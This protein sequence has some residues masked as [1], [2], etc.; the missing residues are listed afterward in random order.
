MIFTSECVWKREVV[1]KVVKGKQNSTMASHHATDENS[2]PG[3]SHSA[4]FNW[5]RAKQETNSIKY[6]QEWRV[7]MTQ[8][9][10]N[11]FQCVQPMDLAHFSTDLL[12]FL[13]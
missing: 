3:H 12:Y 13:P 9:T 5:Q 7:Q 4:S 8:L 11:Q 6:W 2:S 1:K 10:V